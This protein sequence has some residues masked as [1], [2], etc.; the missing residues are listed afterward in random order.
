[1]SR[2]DSS[3]EEKMM[4]A[5]TIATEDHISDGQSLPITTVKSE[6]TFD[7]QAVCLFEMD[8]TGAT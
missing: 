7:Y 4:L 5:T 8:V 2:E 1:V 3:D 6:P